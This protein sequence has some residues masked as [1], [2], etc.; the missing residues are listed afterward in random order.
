VAEIEAV[1]FDLGG[2]LIDWN[3]RH[4]Y[5][6]LFGGDEAAME[7]FLSEICSPAWNAQQDAGRTWRDAVESLAE[8]HPEHRDLIVAY[9]QRWPEMLGGPIEGTV[10]ILRELRAASVPLAALSNW[11]AE[12][13]PIALQGYAFLGWFET[14]VVS[15]EV[16]VAKP[17][18]R[19]FR[20]L[21]DRTG[22]AATATLFID[23]VP[24][25]LTVA[26]GLG[27]P[28]HLFHDPPALRADLQARGLLPD[29]RRD[30]RAAIVSS[31]PPL[32]R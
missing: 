26:A 8:I 7:R 2:V 17:D 27:M 30:A 1:V 15:G 20:H 6:R 18:P 25:N 12:K 31:P 21:L 5:R 13:F 32:D 11:S 10:E 4:L 23:D 24:G 14:I 3:P 19:I 16:G 22:F 28:T 29:I 9:D